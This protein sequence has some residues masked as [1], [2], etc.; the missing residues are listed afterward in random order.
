M[1]SESA[2]SPAPRR[3]SC[4]HHDLAWS[5][6]DWRYHFGDDVLTQAICAAAWKLNAL[7]IGVVLCWKGHCALRPCGRHAELESK[8]IAHYASDRRHLHIENRVRSGLSGDSRRRER[9]RSSGAC[10]NLCR[11]DASLLA[12]VA[13]DLSLSD[14][15]LLWTIANEMRSARKA[16]TSTPRYSHFAVRNTAFRLLRQNGLWN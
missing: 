7:V 5:L 8:Q 6:S 1:T 15:D 4:R 3:S 2:L 12:T 10:R 11:C 9:I 16:S 13:F 14:V